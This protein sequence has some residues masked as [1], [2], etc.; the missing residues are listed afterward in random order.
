[1]ETRT[2]LYVGAGSLALQVAQRLPQWRGWA[3]RRSQAVLPESLLWLPADVTQP[4][5]PAGWPQHAPDYLVIS[6]VPAARTEAAY[7]AA[8]VQGTAHVLDWLRAH[9]QQPRRILFVSSVGVYGQ[10]DGEWVDEHSVT[11]PQRWSGQ[12][13]LEAEQLL[14][15][16]GLPVTLVRLAGIYGGNRRSFLERV[17]QGHHADGCRNRFTNRIHE[18]DAAGLL[19]HLL[20]R[21]AAGEPL[22]SV[23]IGVDDQPAEQAEVVGWLQQQ[24]GVVSVPELLLAAAGT[25]KRCSNALAR[26]TGWVP[27]FASYREGYGEMLR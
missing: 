15:A 10:S 6:L 14:L 8:Y 21:D 7:R 18:Q 24:L 11:A 4:A 13:M 17:R 27:C 26:S 5:C 20:Q 22:A 9:G 25:S 1:M 19:A 12:V 16:S 3:L 2:V 23:Y